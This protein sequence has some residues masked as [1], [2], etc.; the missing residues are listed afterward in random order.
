[1]EINMLTNLRTKFLDSPDP[2]ATENSLV[3][4]V[5]LDHVHSVNRL[6]SVT[7]T[8]YNSESYMRSTSLHS[9]N[10]ISFAPN[11][12]Q[13]RCISGINKLRFMT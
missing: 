2:L 13:F 10:S 7:R 1:M 9:G 5:N 11:S 3:N 6:T 8:F 12:M 4:V